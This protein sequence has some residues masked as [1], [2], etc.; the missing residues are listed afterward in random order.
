MLKPL[1]SRTASILL[2]S[3][4]TIASTACSQ[5]KTAKTPTNQQPRSVPSASPVVGS[6]N[7]AQSTKTNEEA[8]PTSFEMA[9]D[10]AAGGFSVS[11]SA[12]SPEDWKL[13]ADYYQDAI[14]LMKTVKPQ[15]SYYPI[16][17]AKVKEYQ[18]HFDYALE[19]SVALPQPQQPEPE[20]IVVSVPPLKESIASKKMQIPQGVQKILQQNLQ[21]PIAL[22]QELPPL[23]QPA[24]PPPTPQTVEIPIETK[25]VYA[26]VPIQEDSRQAM[27]FRAPIKRRIGGTPIIDVTFNGKRQFEMIVDTGASGTVITQ[28]MAS[29]L[30][31]STV[32]KAKA[33]TA[34]AQSVEFPIGYVD[35][36]EAGGVK[37][38]KVAVAIAGSELENGLLG[39]D[40]FGNYDITIKSNV[41]EFRPRFDAPIPKKETRKSIPIY[42]KK[43]FK[44]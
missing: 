27:V 9:L 1:F 36:I 3:V 11:Q 30:G 20:K 29:S 26:A 24:P 34:S 25:Q 13:V 40:F 42:P 14:N 37:V 22:Q 12:H 16:A 18:R 33:N 17:K 43:L 10:K 28:Q 2:W 7:S 32:G 35:S 41:V 8:I 31:V 44:E 19:K 15:A 39:H 5:E 23:P 6:P 21:S 38:K 4:L